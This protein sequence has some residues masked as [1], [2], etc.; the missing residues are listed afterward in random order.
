MIFITYII[1]DIIRNGHLSRLIVNQRPTGQEV[2]TG[3]LIT[4]TPFDASTLL[5]INLELCRKV[6]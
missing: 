4:K 1:L 6:D 3:F 5:S 2:Q